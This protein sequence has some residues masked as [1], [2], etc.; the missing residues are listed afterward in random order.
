MGGRGRALE[1]SC[2]KEARRPTRRSAWAAREGTGGKH[3]E[4]RNDIIKR[5]DRR[6]DESERE[7]WDLEER[8]KEA[9]PESEE[10]AGGNDRIKRGERRRDD[11]GREE[12]GSPRERRKGRGG[13]ICETCGVARAAGRLDGRKEL[14]I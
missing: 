7:E 2:D 8:K 13:G 6:R 9:V 3:I 12:R 4:A 11:S 1:E 10:R 5:S 14:V